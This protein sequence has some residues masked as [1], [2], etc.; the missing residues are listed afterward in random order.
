M[1]YN[2]KVEVPKGLGNIFGNCI[3]QGLAVLTY[4][5][6]PVAFHLGERLDDPTTLLRS[7][8]DTTSDMLSVLAS[9]NRCTYDLSGHEQEELVTVNYKFKGQLK[10]EDLNKN[11]VKV[12]SSSNDIIVDMIDKDKEVTFTL[13]FSYQRGI[14]SAEE[15]RFKMDRKGLNSSKF[16][17]F[18]TGVNTFDAINVNVNS[19]LNY[20]DVHIKAITNAISRDDL[21]D[22]VVKTYIDCFKSIKKI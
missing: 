15:I 22:D 2:Y 18:P 21:L 19:K 4:G 9:I 12:V 17:V 8:T 10:T 5:W 11:G 14:L 13:V 7:K 3:R 1:E 16:S 6:T 20:D